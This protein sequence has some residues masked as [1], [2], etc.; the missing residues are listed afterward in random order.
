MTEEANANVLAVTASLEQFL[1]Q[2]PYSSVAVPPEDEDGIVATVSR[3]WGDDSLGFFVRDGSEDLYEALNNLVLPER[4]SAIWH[5]DSRKLEVIWTTRRLKEV[6][7]DLV[8]RRFTFTFSG[9]SHECEFAQSSSRLL[10]LAKYVEPVTTSDT[11]FRNMMSFAGYVKLKDDA[12]LGPSFATPLSFWISNIEWDPEDTITLLDNLNFHIT[13]FDNQSPFVILHDV[14]KDG[15]EIAERTRYI[16]TAFPKN[17]K[18][19]AIDPNLL[20]FW[21]AA[22]LTNQMM[23][24][25]IYYRM[26]E[27]CAVQYIDHTTR[28]KLNALL[29]QP[30]LQDSLSSAVEQ[31]VSLVGQKELDDIPRLKAVIRNNVKPK[32]IWQDIYGNLPFFSEDCE[33]DG[34]FVVKALV[35]ATETQEGFCKRGLDQFADQLRKIRNALSHGKDH[36]TA[37]VI[38]PTQRNM[39]LLRPWVHLIATTAGDV[40]LY[41]DVT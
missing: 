33:F 17:I 7:S 29:S 2:N 15:N 34:G 23:Q 36:E 9:T 21:N 40:A 38:L 3:P 14:S 22:Q 12:E 41:K 1:A 27:Y 10:A 31:I 18:A 4:L 35:G 32:H 5:T 39:D 26:I 16:N 13:Y 28:A 37:G 30:D 11:M 19:T 25:I 20:E 24:F 6:W 8:G